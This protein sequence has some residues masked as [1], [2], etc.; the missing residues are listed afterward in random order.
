MKQVRNKTGNKYFLSQLI[1]CY[2]SLATGHLNSPFIHICYNTDSFCYG[3]IQHW[4][5]ERKEEFILW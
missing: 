3:F 4:M 5:L 2:S 1:I